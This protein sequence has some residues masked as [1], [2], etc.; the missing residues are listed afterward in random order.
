M[1]KVDKD[2]VLQRVA[3]SLDIQFEL[4]SW[5]K[6]LEDTFLPNEKEELKYAKEHI[7]Y[8]AYITD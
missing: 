3:K 7:G 2:Y 1:K 4:Y 5:E 8:K 6:M